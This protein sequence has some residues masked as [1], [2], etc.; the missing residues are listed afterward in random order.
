M[1]QRDPAAPVTPESF[2]WST[3][4]ALAKRT[5]S[6]YGARPALAGDHCQRRGRRARHAG[7][8]QLEHGR[9]AREA[10]PLRLRCAARSRQARPGWPAEPLPAAFLAAAPA[11]LKA[12]HEAEP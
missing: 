8:L 9:R 3:A 7:N 6:D 11:L 5:R 12:F 2:N 10:D 4:A 1:P